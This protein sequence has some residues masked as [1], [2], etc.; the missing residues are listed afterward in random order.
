MAKRDYHV[1]IVLHKELS[2]PGACGLVT[3]LAPIG[4][5]LLPEADC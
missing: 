3:N 4:M 2:P 1:M 5:P